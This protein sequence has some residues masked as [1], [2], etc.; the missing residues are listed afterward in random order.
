MGTLTNG[1]TKPVDIVVFRAAQTEVNDLLVVF[2]DP[3]EAFGDENAVISDSAPIVAGEGCEALPESRPTA[4]CSLGSTTEFERRYYTERAVVRAELGDRDDRAQVQGAVRRFDAGVDLSGGKG[5]DRLMGGIGPGL[6]SGGPGDDVMIGR[7]FYDTFSEGP[8]PSGSDTIIAKE[9]NPTISYAER[10]RGV[11][12]DLTG[13]RDDG[14]P[15]ERDRVVIKQPRAEGG[16]ILIGGRGNDR[17]TGDKL[18]NTLVGA[19]GRDVLRGGPRSDY[20]WA[21]TEELVPG[22]RFARGRDADWLDGGAGDDI[23]VGN[24]GPNTLR[25]GAGVDGV[26]GGP[27]R[28]LLLS[29]D[30]SYDDVR[31]GTGIDTALLDTDDFFTNLRDRRCEKPRRSGPVSALPRPVGFS[32]EFPIPLKGD[33]TYVDDYAGARL[34]LGCPGDAPRLC[35]G[36]V[37]VRYRGRILGST[38]FRIRRNTAPRD[39]N[40]LDVWVPFRRALARRLINYDI[41][42]AVI[43]CRFRD[44]AGRLR[45]TDTRT[46][47][48]FSF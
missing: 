26:W 43:V 35:K 25:G 1:R 13:D 33:Y 2:T 21:H 4:R 9:Y 12:V 30:D 48:S 31:C 11:R 46:F 44:R 32:T 15:G 20:L 29:R 37:F 16:A 38:R 41:D 19:G 28:D 27:G 42:T 39:R 3:S 7:G 40:E 18:E 8:L 34:D 45:Q 24:R 10:S 14:A 23:V 17:L 47:L 22:V 36:R 6:F 5:G